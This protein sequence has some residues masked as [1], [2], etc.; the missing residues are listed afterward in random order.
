VWWKKPQKNTE[1]KASQTIGGI[2]D[3]EFKKFGPWVTK[4]VIDGKEYGGD[5]DALN[6]KRLEWFFQ[7]F[8]DTSTIL[9][10]G[11]LEGGHTFSLARHPSVKRVL[12]IEGR[13][14]NIHRAQFV[15][16]LLKVDNVEFI[17]ANLEK[18]NLVSWGQFDAVFC[19]GLLYHLPDPLSLI[20]QISQVSKNLFIWTHYADPA[21]ADKVVNGYRGLLYQEY[22]MA[23][24]LSGMSA[25]SFWP[26]L[27]ALTEMLNRYGFTTINI[28][29]DNPLHPHGP[30][31]TLAAKK[32]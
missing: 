13:E 11:S 18:A 10:L 15:Q 16:Q 6:D 27:E 28:I 2:L 19:V 3:N 32:P 21:K 5:F 25:K 23:D 1:I 9:E 26:T 12:G 29:E 20:E 8:S 31:I 14:S 17:S 4:F 24:S 22:G 7:N 30:S